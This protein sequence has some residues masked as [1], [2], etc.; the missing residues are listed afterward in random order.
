MRK[1][2][3]LTPSEQ[4]YFVQNLVENAA[5][6]NETKTA[7]CKIKMINWNPYPFSFFSFLLLVIIAHLTY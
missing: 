6:N 1:L 4:L 3:K 7:Q 5:N 2:A